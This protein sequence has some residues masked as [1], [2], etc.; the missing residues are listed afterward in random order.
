M[1]KVF[2][3]VLIFPGQGS[4]FVGMGKEVYAKSPRIFEQ[5]NEILGFSLTKLIFEGDLNEL[6]RTSNAQPAIL[7]TCIALYDLYKDVHQFD[8]ILGHSVGEYASLVASNSIPFVEALKLVR[9]RGEIMEVSSTR[10]FEMTV[11]MGCPLET[12]ETICKE[13]EAKTNLVCEIAAINSDSQITLSGDKEAIE[14]ACTLAKEHGVRRPIRLKVGGA[15]HS[16]LMIPASQLMRSHLNNVTWKLPEIP[17]I[18]NVTGK[19]YESTRDIP[20]LLAHQI[21]TCVNFYAGMMYCKSQGSNISFIEMGPKQ[22]LLSLY[23][24]EDTTYIG[25]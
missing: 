18:S 11:F 9:K 5:A 22:S 13:T 3:K 8:A 4:Q 1:K 12:A 19:P 16:K 15:F 21:H 10:E 25:N 2:K 14:Y 7:T 17:V 24:N 20:D 23:K 6:T